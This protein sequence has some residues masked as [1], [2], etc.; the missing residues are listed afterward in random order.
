[1]V[2]PWLRGTREESPAAIRAILHAL[3]QA[4]EDVRRWTADLTAQELE[5]SPHNL[6]PVAFQMRHISRSL[7]RLLT[8]AEDGPRAESEA[9]MS[10]DA[11]L[12]EVFSAISASRGRVAA[13]GGEDFEAARYVGRA[14]LKVTLG[15]LLVHIA[16]HTQRHV[17]QLITTSK[18]VR[19]SRPS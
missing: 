1:M 7:D 5:A 19:A 17:G 12:T 18:V 15:G 10:R 6:P 8:Y 4:E 16:E 11:M 3:D 14:R 9:G 13:L 2:E